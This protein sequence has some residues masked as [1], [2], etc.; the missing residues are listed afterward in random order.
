MVERIAVNQ[1]PKQAAPQLPFTPQSSFVQRLIQL[2]VTL[3][4]ANTP[5]IAQPSHFVGVGGPSSNKVTISG[6]RTTARIDHVGGAQ[7]SSAQVAV[8]GLAP[9]LMN[10]LSQTGQTYD[11]VRRNSVAI[12]AGDAVGLTP[13]FLGTIK[14]CYGDYT[15]QPDVPLQFVCQGGLIDAVAAAQPLSFTGK[16]TVSQIMSGFASAL[17]L[18]F[19]NSGITGALVNAYYAGTVYQQLKRVAHDA[20]IDYDIINNVLCIWPLGG[21]RTAAVGAA[22]VPLISKNTGMIATPSFSANGYLTVKSLFNP[23]IGRGSQVQIESDVIPQVNGKWVVYQINLALDS[24]VP[25]GQWNMDMACYPFG[26]APPPLP[27]L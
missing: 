26:L 15:Q 23:N 8:Y 17:N 13:V 10:Q 25:H 20:H 24:L 9:N 2:E 16:A 11:Q 18:G 19:E 4:S 7:G 12:S 1:S 22:A 5:G 3:S 6:A 27:P 14:F 21:S